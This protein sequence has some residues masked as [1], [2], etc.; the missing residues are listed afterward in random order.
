VEKRLD[1][2]ETVWQADRQAISE[3]SWDLQWGVQYPRYGDAAER[4]RSIVAAHDLDA[5]GMARALVVA[6][7]RLG[8]PRDEAERIA[9]L[10][11][12]AVLAMAARPEEAA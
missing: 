5:A 8:T 11:A 12:E 2:L 3:A 9:R 6:L 10:G 4:Y 1:R 7:V